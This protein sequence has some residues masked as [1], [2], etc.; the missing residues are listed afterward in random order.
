MRSGPTQRGSE[1]ASAAKPGVSLVHHGAL[2]T[3]PLEGFSSYGPTV[4]GRLKPEVV[5]PDGT[6]TSDGAFYGTSSACPHAAG[7]VALYVGRGWSPLAAPQQVMKDALPLGVGQPNPAYGWGRVHPGAAAL[8]WQFL[9][10]DGKP[11]KPAGGRLKDIANIVPP[12]RLPF[13]QVD[14]LCDV[15][16]PLYG[17]KGAS[18]KDDGRVTG[19]R[20]RIPHSPPRSRA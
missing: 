14:V 18:W 1:R 17:P 6:A 10:A 9:D 4:D 16:N 13:E 5:A 12:V 2:E 20:V 8:G 3:G 11:V 15:T 7:V 19:T